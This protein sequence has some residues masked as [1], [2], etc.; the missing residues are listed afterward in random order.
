MAKVFRLWSR[1]VWVDGA[2][3][4]GDTCSV[5]RSWSWLKRHFKWRH[6]PCGLKW[7]ES[8]DL[9]LGLSACRR[10]ASP[11]LISRRRSLGP[12]IF[13]RIDVTIP[14][15]NCSNTNGNQGLFIRHLMLIQA[16]LLHIVALAPPN[17]MGAIDF[18][19]ECSWSCS[20]WSA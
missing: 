3:I 15:W 4:P 8:L 2:F 1:E 19:A 11:D 5:A 14:F 6:R 12:A 18:F 10:L 7:V 16:T 9:L 17:P 20:I 13:R